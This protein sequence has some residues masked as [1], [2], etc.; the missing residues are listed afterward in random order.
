M[1]HADYTKLHTDICVL[2]DEINILFGDEEGISVTCFVLL[3]QRKTTDPKSC[4]EAVP[5]SILL[6][7]IEGSR[8]ASMAQ[9]IFILLANVTKRFVNKRNTGSTCKIVQ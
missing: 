2:G 7:T 4:L 8:A 3:Q 6:D 5:V 1:I 9:N